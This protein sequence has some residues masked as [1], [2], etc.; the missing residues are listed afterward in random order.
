MGYS[1]NI[2]SILPDIL[3]FLRYSASMN[4]KKHLLLAATFMLTACGTANKEP[5]IGTV[6][7]LYT[8]GQAA[9]SAGKYADAIHTFQELERQHPYSEWATRAQMMVAFAH[10]QSNNVEEASASAERFIRL[11][12]GHKDLPYLY[13]IRGLAFYKNISDVNRDQGATRKAAEAFQELITRFPD[14]EYARDAKQKLLLTQDHLAG[15]EMAIG[16]YYQGQDHYLAAI[17]RFQEVVEKYQTS[18]QTPEALLRLTESYIALGIKDEAERNAA[19]LG[20]NYPGSDWYKRAYGLLRD[21]GYLA[22]ADTE[23][24]WADKMRNRFNAV[25][26]AF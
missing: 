20:H 8:S 25:K 1:F 12:P 14:S 5:V 18:S 23:E 4:K 22:E 21:E 13:Y 15:K 9:L 11:H 24:S 6:D 7:S 2:S 16:R 19:I 26:D 17:N 3:F 10:L